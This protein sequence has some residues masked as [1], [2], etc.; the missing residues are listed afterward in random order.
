MAPAWTLKSRRP[1]AD[2][3]AFEV[4]P[5]GG[6]DEMQAAGQRDARIVVEL[7]VAL[8][9]RVAGEDRLDDAW[10]EALEAR[11]EIEG[12]L[13]RCALPRDDHLPVRPYVR[14]RR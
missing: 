6:R 13:P 7:N 9:R 4:E 14:R 8:E 5:C 10:R 12:Q 3:S 11:V 1:L 2:L